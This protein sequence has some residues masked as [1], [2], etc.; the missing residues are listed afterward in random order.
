MCYNLIMKIN[1]FKN[2]EYWFEPSDNLKDFTCEMSRNDHGFLCGLIKK[3]KPHKI[4][5]I[6]I[7]EG[8]TTGV[9]INAL[10][11]L[12]LDYKMYSVDISDDFSGNGIKTGYELD[13]FDLDISNH[14]F[15]FGKSIA[16]FIDDIGNDIDFVVLDTVH[17]VPGE[18]LDIL[19]ILPY[20]SKNAVIVMH[21][22]DLCRIYSL[23]KEYYDYY[24]ESISN[25]LA[26]LSIDG[27]KYLNT[28]L[29][30]LYGNDLSNICAVK[31]NDNTYKNVINLFY[32]LTMPWSYK[33]SDRLYEEY[34]SIFK[35][36][37]NAECLDIF[38]SAYLYSN[39]YKCTKNKNIDNWK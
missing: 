32:S 19:T 23:N 16:G 10:N 35:K 9:I 37:Y 29:N 28:N 39:N 7:A 2:V 18:I 20:L 17:I 22:V 38:K 13:K 27:E 3:F 25:K 33:L 11:I 15:L 4:V 14:K 12:N 36:Y 34:S 24:E 26:F 31:V 1:N 6:G 21:D 5:E 8:G 30:G